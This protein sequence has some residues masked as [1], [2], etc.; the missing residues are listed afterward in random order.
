MK[1][2][3]L[4]LLASFLI[5]TSN[6]VSAQLEWIK[7]DGELPENAVIGGVETHRSL[8]ICRCNYK[9]A[10]HPGKVVERRCNIGWGGKEIG[11]KRFEVLVNKG[12]IELDWQ[13]TDGKKLPNHAVKAG[14]ENGRALYVGRAHH[15]AGTHPGKVFQAGKGY[16]CNIGYGEKE[17]TYKTFEVL[18]ENKPHPDNKRIKHD[19]R[20]GSKGKYPATI[21][22][23][24]G[25]M[26]KERMVKEGQSLVSTNLRYQ[27]RVTDDG[28]LVVEEILDRALCD[29]SKIFVFQANEI[30]SNTTK[31]G[32]SKLDYYLKF[33]EDGNLC[34]YSEQSGFVWCS[35]SN[36]KNGH[37]LELT[38]IGHIEIVNDHGGEVWPD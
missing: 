5:L 1:I 22:S 8:A 19:D 15:E 25:N 11:L 6:V 31:K 20:C 27:T 2:V 13:K 12:V 10:M 32:D 4:L 37:H 23:Y 16:I 3:K 17:I 28:R 26:S 24:I 14:E 33:Q 21:G 9:G 29:N 7:F 34:I 18:V 30:W 36:G 38:N 35:M